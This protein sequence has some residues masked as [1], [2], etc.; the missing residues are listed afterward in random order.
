VAERVGEVRDPPPD[1]IQGLAFARRARG[2]CALHRRVEVVDDEIEV[3][4]RPVAG[5]APRRG[6]GERRAPG[7]L[8][9]QEHARRRTDELHGSRAEA[10]TRPEPERA[11]VELDALL[12]IGN[13]EVHE[14][15]G[16]RTHPIG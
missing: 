8:L 10:S 4:G 13:V 9:E 2:D 1:L 11:R 12:E 5:V 14:E 16:Q 3:N 7:L 6:R 15:V